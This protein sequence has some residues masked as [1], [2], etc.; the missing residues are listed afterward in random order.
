MGGLGGEE[1][2]PGF[3][4]YD[5]WRQ[6]NRPAIQNTTHCVGNG[7][8]MTGIRLLILIEPF[9]AAVSWALGRRAGSAGVGTTCAGGGGPAAAPGAGSEQVLAGRAAPE[10][11]R[12]KARLAR[13]LRA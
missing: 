7:P 1:G 2:E 9:K 4:R 12:T 8:L 11:G 13:G 6:M 5:L 10:P 3:G